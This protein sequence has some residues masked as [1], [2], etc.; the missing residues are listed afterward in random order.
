[1]EE[2]KFHF[3]IIK[4]HLTPSLELKIK[5]LLD[6]IGLVFGEEIGRP[7]G[8]LFLVNLAFLPR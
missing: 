6:E 1:V 3:H 5:D 8:K 4:S 2:D 7:A